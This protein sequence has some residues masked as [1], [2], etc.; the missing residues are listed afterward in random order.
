[1]LINGD[2]ASATGILVDNNEKEAAAFFPSS[3]F[4]GREA[5]INSSRVLMAT[6]GGNGAD[7]MVSY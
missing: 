1:M 7:D 5:L 4:V 3:L 2:K 6:V